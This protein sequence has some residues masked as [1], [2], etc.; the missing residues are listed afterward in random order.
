MVF[1]ESLQ[2]FSLLYSVPQFIENLPEFQV[3]L[4]LQRNVSSIK[5]ANPEMQSITR[6]PTAF[7]TADAPRGQ[8]PA[9]EQDTP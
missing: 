8:V 5:E 1:G 9:R 6:F 3:S 7:R 2:F 4:G